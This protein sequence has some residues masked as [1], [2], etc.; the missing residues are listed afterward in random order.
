MECPNA[1]GANAA[2]GRSRLVGALVGAGGNQPATSQRRTVMRT[3]AAATAAV[4]LT[5]AVLAGLVAGCSSGGEGA[6][7]ASPS[8]LAPRQNTTTSTLRSPS[9]SSAAGNVSNANTSVSTSVP[10]GPLVGAGR[11][12]LLSGFSSCDDFLAKVRTIALEHVT[13]WGLVGSP[14]IYG[15]VATDGGPFRAAGAAT[16]AA[17][18]AAA[19]PT[20]GPVSEGAS[21]D[22]ASS[23]TNTQE[24]GVDE[25]DQVENDGRY[26]Y[27]VLSGVLRVVDTVSG[28]AAVVDTNVTSQQIVLAG[29]RLVAVGGG[30]GG[31]G[32]MASIAPIGNLANGQTTTVT[33][34]DVTD[35]MKPTPVERKMIE[36][37]AIAVRASGDVV[38]I[39]MASELGAQLD[40][41]MPNRPGTTVEAK[42]KKANEDTINA[43]T[44]DQWLPRV[45]DVAVDGSVGK[46]TAALAC[47]DAAAP[48]TFAGLGMTWVASIDL[49]N[50]AT[51]VG[52]A[53]VIAQ[54]A[55]AYASTDNLYVATTTWFDA[56]SDPDVRKVKAEPLRTAIHAFALGSGVSARYSASGEVS[57]VL[58]NSYSMSELDGSLRIATTE[59]PAQFGPQTS[60]TVS[61]LRRSGDSLDVVGSVGG[62][63]S[64]EQ[65][66]AVRFLGPTGYVVTFRQTDPLYV[67]DL[68]DPAHPKVAGELKIP[69]FSAYLHPVGDGLLL[70]IG[71]DA[72]NQGRQLGLQLSLLD[73][74]DPAKPVRL[75]NVDLGGQSEAQWDPH[76]FLFWPTSDGAESGSIVVPMIDYG[77]SYTASGE[78]TGQPKMGA[79]VLDLHDRTIEQRGVVNAVCQCD[80]NAQSNLPSGFNYVNYVAPVRRSMIVGGKL[81]TLS[82]VGLRVSNLDSLR[83]ERVVLFN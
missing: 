31:V 25:G 75:T 14:I 16:T 46:P 65:I 4:P 54:G 67:V 37:S 9:T 81:V 22:S 58:L 66:F 5:L 23:G 51:V 82:D 7:V 55:I 2:A 62:L 70:G 13:A 34:Y 61:V 6:G 29:K 28:E 17:A 53:G 47:S 78:W 76:A 45:I 11:S 35:P 59:Q 77:G 71:Q 19:R 73:V 50:A 24:I 64:G 27:N 39:V 49:A 41:V 74:H 33:V 56:Q 1:G 44:A 42:A 20:A 43:S 18:S 52:S 40:F 80:E 68:H 15:G 30:W 48:T 83:S 21:K 38:R 12:R 63:G 26:V 32:P 8:T 36:G 10:A 79:S 69:G 3:R 60:S 72:T 57:G